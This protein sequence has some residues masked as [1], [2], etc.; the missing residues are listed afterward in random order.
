MKRCEHN[1]QIGEIS[2]TPHGSTLA[3]QTTSYNDLESSCPDSQRTAVQSF[4][5]LYEVF[6][7]EVQYSSVEYRQCSEIQCIGVKGNTLRCT[8]GEEGGRV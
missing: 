6:N 8:A 7:G 1:G 3:C 4:A 2:S 5:V